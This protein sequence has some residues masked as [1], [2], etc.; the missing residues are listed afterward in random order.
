MERRHICVV[1]SEYILH[2]FLPSDGETLPCLASGIR[3][4][5]VFEVGLAKMCQVDERDATEIEGHQESIS[6][7]FL[8]GSMVFGWIH[9]LDA[10]DVFCR[11]GSLLGL[12]DTSIDIL[13]GILLSGISFLYDFVVGCP[14]DAKI[15]RTGVGSYPC[16]VLQVCFVGLYLF[17]INLFEGDVLV[18]SESYVTVE[19]LPCNAA[20]CEVARSSSTGRWGGSWMKIT[21]LMFSGFLP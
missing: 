3:D 11:N 4:K 16:H 17:G 19:G 8:F 9:A 21:T 7:R 2:L 13:E 10:A 18:I 1:A 15:E 5:T 6:C 12:G 20:W 14:K